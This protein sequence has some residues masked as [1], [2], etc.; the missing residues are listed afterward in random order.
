MADHC[1]HCAAT[2]REFDAQEAHAALAQRF[3]RLATMVAKHLSADDAVTP[4]ARA[5]RAH[6]MRKVWARIVGGVEVDEGGYPDCALIGQ[7]NSN[8]TLT[9]YCTGALIHPRIVLTAGHCVDAAEGFRPNLVALSCTDMNRL[10]NAELVPAKT[11]V[12]NPAYGVEVAHD[13]SVI[14]LRKDATTEPVKR[15][16]TEELTAAA[17]TTLVGFGNSDFKSTRGFGRKRKVD[18]D[19]G[20][21]RRKPADDLNDA[22]HE[23]GFESDLEFTAGG[24][25][26][27]SC[28]GD[29]GGPAYIAIADKYR[30]AGLT[31][32]ALDTAQA[33]CGDG[34]IYTRVDV[35]KK[36]ISEVGAKYGINV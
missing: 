18:V 10:T 35:H 14:V 12:R 17:E 25:G 34:G 28:N 27:D 8:G 23:L 21:L 9:W 19:I 30:L 31:S 26:Y 1:P 11:C 7:K 16:T 5:L 4:Q 36:F 15:A 20:Y 6:E 3:D 29:S 33:P 22:E 13:I 2:K 32:R 24:E